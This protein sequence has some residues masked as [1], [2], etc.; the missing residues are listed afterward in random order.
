MNQNPDKNQL[1]REMLKQRLNLSAS[2]VEARSG[3]VIKRLKQLEPL[4][5]SQT[6]MFYSSIKN[7]VDLKPV[8]EEEWQQG[9]T[10]LLPR[11]R[12][13]SLEA[14][15]FQGWDNCR[16]GAFGILEPEGPAYNPQHIEAILVPGVA[17]DA[18]GYRI[19]YGKGYYDRFLPGCARETFLCGAAYE[20]QVLDTINPGESDIPL[21]WIVTD[22]SELAI[23]MRFF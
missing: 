5:N 11:V 21:H 18:R 15:V 17:F 22:C 4:R 1:R 12:D 20:F 23:D 7:E 19:G 8:F 3:Q 2:E 16:P 6:I 13:N 10:I 14:V 9:K